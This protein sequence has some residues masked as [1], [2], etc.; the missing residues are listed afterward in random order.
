MISLVPGPGLRR[1]VPDVGQ[2]ARAHA[3]P[4]GAGSWHAFPMPMVRSASR[5]EGLL[6]VLARELGQ[7]R[8]LDGSRTPQ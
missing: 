8:A 5:S 4:V 1:R 2:A 3:E 6:H 7:V